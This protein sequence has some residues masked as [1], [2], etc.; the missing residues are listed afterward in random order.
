MP[1]CTSDLT[2]PVWVYN[3]GESGWILAHGA[4]GDPTVIVA[5]TPDRLDRTL[6][7]AAQAL[8]QHTEGLRQRVAQALSTTPVEV[9]GDGSAS[10]VE[11]EPTPTVDLVQIEL[12]DA[13]QP[14]RVSIFAT[15]GHPS[16]YHLYEVQLEG[17]TVT[18]LLGG[19]W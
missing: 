3:P 16:P 9:R 4:P 10:V 6:C 17:N 2:P 8:L 18:A 15:T 11:H 12:R 5:G 1:D 7:D 19:F 14:E 13:S